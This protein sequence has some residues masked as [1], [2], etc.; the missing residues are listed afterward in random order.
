MFVLLT[1]TDGETVLLPVRRVEFL[2]ACEGKTTTLVGL[3]SGATF[4]IAR[5]VINVAVALG[6]PW[7]QEYNRAVQE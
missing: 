7:R 5:P 3:E 2:E 6:D 1:K 4:K